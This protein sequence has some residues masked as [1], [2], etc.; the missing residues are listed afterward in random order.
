MSRTRDAFA[1]AC[2]VG[3][4][5]GVLGDGERG[6]RVGGI[7]SG[8]LRLSLQTSQTVSRLARFGVDVSDVADYLGKKY[9]GWVPVAEAYGKLGNKWI[10][11]P[12]AINGGY[13]NYRVSQIKAA[14]IAIHLLPSLP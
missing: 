3:A 7:A 13:I 9:G 1:F 2:L 4:S 14:G 12:A 6:A 5:S 11:I 8:V 10:A